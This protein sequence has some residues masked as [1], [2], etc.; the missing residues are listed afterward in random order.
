MVENVNDKP[1]EISSP[2]VDIRNLVLRENM[3]NDSLFLITAVDT[4]F[5]SKLSI[6]IEVGLNLLAMFSRV[7]SYS[8]FCDFRKRAHGCR[9]GIFN[10]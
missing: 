8:T 7:E 10:S 1:P 6:Y 3:D 2:M 9:S 5:N 4:E